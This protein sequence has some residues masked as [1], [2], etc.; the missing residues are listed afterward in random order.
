M[1]TFVCVISNRLLQSVSA[2]RINCREKQGIGGRLVSQLCVIFKMHSLGPT[3]TSQ[4]L[5]SSPSTLGRDN[6]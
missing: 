3:I 5:C 1:S 6:T 2:E 4:L